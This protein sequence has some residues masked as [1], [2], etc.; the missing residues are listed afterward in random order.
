VFSYEGFAGEVVSI[1][2][3]PMHATDT[4]SAQERL[5]LSINGP[6]GFTAEAT[7]A[8]A[9]ELRVTLPTNGAY[10][11]TVRSRDP[12]LIQPGGYSIRMEEHE[13]I[14]APSGD[15]S[16]YTLPGG[17]VAIDIDP[18]PVAAG[19]SARLLPVW[20]RHGRSYDV[21]FSCL[22]DWQVKAEFAYIAEANQTLHVGHDAPVGSRIEV[23]ATV[24][25]QRLASFVEVAAAPPPPQP[26]Q[27][28][29]IV[30]SCPDGSRWIVGQNC[31]TSLPAP[32]SLFFER[33][34]P[35]CRVK[36]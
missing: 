23:N 4:S 6:A 21:Q 36:V 26:D 9:N 15:C 17:Y 19:G 24:G 31:P 35:N 2:L 27:P 5:T 12:M 33:E 30:E 1:H 10:R 18:R 13:A 22:T 20:S 3:D 11:V 32:G 29:V 16:R 8:A 7:A 25:G 28:A 34:V 14:P